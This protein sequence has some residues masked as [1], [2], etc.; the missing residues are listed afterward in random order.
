MENEQ[1][2]LNTESNDIAGNRIDGPV[3]NTAAKPGRPGAGVGLPGGPP[4]PDAG[5]AGAAPDVSSP[6]APASSES[7]AA[8]ETSVGEGAVEGDT[9]PQENKEASPAALTPKTEAYGGNFGNSTQGSYRDQDRRENQDSD[10]N[11]GEF[12]VQDQGGTTHG[13][14]GNQNRLADYEPRDSAED[15][16]YGG[17]GR[18][19]PQDNAYRAYDGRDERPDSQTEYGFERGTQP[20]TTA[21]QAADASQ[22]RG[23]DFAGPNAD[24]RNQ[25]D[26]ADPNSAHQD[27]NGSGKGPDSSFASDY[28]HT[29]LR[30]AA[31]T[32]AQSS[33]PDTSGRR[34]QTEDYLPAQGGF[35]K[36]GRRDEQHPNNVPNNAPAAADQRGE[37]PASSKGYGDRGREEPRRDPDFN[38]GDDR[39]GYVKAN[40]GDAAQGIGSRG[41]SYNDAYDDSRPGSK[42]GSP[43]KGDQRHEDAASSYGSEAREENRAG[44]DNKV[45]HGAPKRNAGRE[46]EADE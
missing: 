18:P 16:Y 15:R 32:A 42:A 9:K 12:G 46:G 1:N 10:P 20:A 2:N 24:N 6:T 22:S 39:N 45:D 35:D 23:E 36:Q 44:D 38:T 37:Q 19:G 3:G 33:R 40:G 17:P 11:R 14:F 41:G 43:A 21:G 30:G 5:A 7:L 13:G 26:R 29:S 31:N 8:S 34:N 4:A 25:P 28:G 27:D